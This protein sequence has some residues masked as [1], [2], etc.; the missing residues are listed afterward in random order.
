M[1]NK[2]RHLASILGTYRQSTNQRAPFGEEHAYEPN[3]STL[4]PSMASVPADEK[5]LGV[6]YTCFQGTDY[7]QKDGNT[8]V[9]ILDLFY[10]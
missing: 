7:I 5:L 4:P 10:L 9:K 6:E 3:F 1:D 8:I 2:D